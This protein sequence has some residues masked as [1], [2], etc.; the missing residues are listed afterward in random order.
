MRKIMRRDPDVSLV[1]MLAMI[2]LAAAP[3]LGN[4]IPGVSTTIY[5]N[6]HFEVRDDDQ[7]VK[8]VWNGATRI[9]HITG[10]LSANKRIQRLRVRPGWNL[11]SLAVNAD[12]VATQ[13]GGTTSNP[14]R[15]IYR[16]N[17]QT[18]GYATVSAGEPVSAGAVLWVKAASNATIAV[19]GTYAEPV[20]RQ[21]TAGG[22]YLATTGLEAWS[23]TFPPTLAVWSYFSRPRVNDA[24]FTAWRARLTGDL[25]FVANLPRTFAPGNAIYVDAAAPVLLETPP[26]ALRI[27]YYHQDHLGSS[28]VMTD[29]SGALVEETAFYP[30]GVSRNESHLQGVEEHYSF[31]Q[32]ER[33]RESSLHYFEARHLASGLSRFVSVDQKYAHPN[34]LTTNELAL[35]LANPRKLNPYAYV[36]NNPARWIDRDGFSP[37][38]PFKTPEAAA[39]D[40]LLA[41]NPRSMWENREFGGLIYYDPRDKAYYATPPA[42]GMLA[43]FNPHAV[44]VPAGTATVG[45]YHTHGDYTF[46]LRTPTGGTASVHPVPSNMDSFLS[47]QFSQTDKTGITADAAGIPGY[48]GYLGTPSGNFHQF[49]P[50]TGTVLA[51]SIR[52]SGRHVHLFDPAAAKAGASSA[53]P[54][55]TAPGC[56]LTGGGSWLSSFKFTCD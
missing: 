1:V 40:A 13:F 26:P 53:S 35:L 54:A 48:K 55:K 31:T 29:A 46:T 19:S 45:D 49:D 39:T 25:A 21:I 3:A 17:Q 27:R 33:D 4:E 44:N 14:V 2:A 36:M 9:A 15:A 34:K 23:P 52:T 32:K 22:T 8:Y 51:L 38:D 18:R 50:A 24:P 28:S 47:D 7:P 42:S 12:D 11:L 37:G 43:S 10:S 5:V 41:A 6:K 20:N 30:F 16:W 56:K